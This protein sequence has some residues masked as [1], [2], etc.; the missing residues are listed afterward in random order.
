MV[1][2]SAHLSL[3]YLHAMLAPV[4]HAD[5][6]QWLLFQLPF[7]AISMENM[8]D[9]STLCHEPSYS[10]WLPVQFWGVHE[11]FSPSYT[12]ITYR[13]S[14]IFSLGFL[15]GLHCAESLWSW[16]ITWTLDIY[17]K[18]ILGLLVLV[19]YNKHFQSICDFCTWQKQQTFSEYLGLCTR[20]Q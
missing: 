6:N 16:A 15:K 13:P 19:I 8:N 20:Y 17:G 4:V 11:F 10:Q 12:I 9:K 1:V 2:K 18:W 7:R 5:S 3:G 14:L